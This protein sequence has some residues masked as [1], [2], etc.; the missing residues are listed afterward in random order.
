MSGEEVGVIDLKDEVFGCEY[1]EY[2]IHQAVVT[3]LANERQGTKCTL[4]RAEVRGGGIKPWRQKGT[5]RARQGSI[6]SPQWKGGGVVFAPKPRDFSKKM[7]VKAKRAAI[8]SA[9][10]EKVRNGDFIVLDTLSL[11]E[12]KTKEM[13]KLLAGLKV[14]KKALV[15]LSKENVSAVRAGGNI[16][17]VTTIYS[18]LIN[19]YDIVNNGKI[20]IDKAEVEKVT[21]VFAG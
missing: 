1:N 10:S 2:L 15:V 20:I 7:N 11:K 12:A 13:V 4:T 18:E 17:A 21:E 9:L 19:T 8:R 6:R 3:R 14:D 16:P 5:G